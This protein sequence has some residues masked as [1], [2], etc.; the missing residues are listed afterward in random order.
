MG[1]KNENRME[2]VVMGRDS[3]MGV[4]DKAS[5]TVCALFTA[6][7]EYLGFGFPTPHPIRNL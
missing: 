2:K 5:W 1:R 4:N 6:S 7:E 3:V